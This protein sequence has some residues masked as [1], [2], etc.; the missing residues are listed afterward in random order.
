MRLRKILYFVPGAER[1]EVVRRW[2]LLLPRLPRGLRPSRPT[3]SLADF[4]A[5]G[6]DDDSLAVLPKYFT[7]LI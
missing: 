6:S 3:F 2:C 5:A 1:R 7:Q 4:D